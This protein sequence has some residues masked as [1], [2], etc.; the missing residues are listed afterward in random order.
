M[1]ENWNYASRYLEPLAYFTS[2]VHLWRNVKGELA[3][4]LIRDNFLTYL[5]I[6][7]PY[8]D[9]ESEMF[10][11]A[12]RNWAGENNQINTLVYDWDKKRQ[13]LLAQRGYENRGA[14][15]DVRIYDL[16]MTYPE[17]QL[18][19]NF[20]ITSLADFGNFQ[21]RIDLENSIWGASLDETWFRGKSSAP[22]YSSD[23]DLLAISPQGK[24]AAQSLVWLYPNNQTAEIDPLGTHPDF[25]KLGLAKILVLESFKR[26]H[27]HGIHYAYIASETQDPIVNH[28]YSSL[29]PVEIYQGFHWAKQI[30]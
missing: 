26:M 9:L 7:Y 5:Q 2:R 21:A 30:S 25:R 28:L 8:R 16:S 17:V 15:E 23:W 3:S 12:E 22:S 11:W 13:T 24:L 14:I 1:A 10:D 29:Q 4:Y 19:V 20:Q 6:Q 18:P 27:D